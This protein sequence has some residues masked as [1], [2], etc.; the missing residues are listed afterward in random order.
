MLHHEVY[1]AER[2][3]VLF[4]PRDSEFVKLQDKQNK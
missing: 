4:K 2:G 3:I 1:S